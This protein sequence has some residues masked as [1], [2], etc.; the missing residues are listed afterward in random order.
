MS[1]NRDNSRQDGFTLIEVLV[2]L[3]VL[4]IGLLGLAAL[5]T[6]GVRFNHDAAV[7]TQAT[8]L[9]QDMLERL[10]IQRMRLEELERSG[11]PPALTYPADLVEFTTANFPAEPA[12]GYVCNNATSAAPASQLECWLAD[13]TNMLPEGA[14]TIEQQAA[15]LATLDIELM[16]L[17]R[18]PRSFGGVTRLPATQVECEAL[19]MRQWRNPNCMVMQTWT[20]TP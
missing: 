6:Q 16:W 20:V 17:D 5:Q 11:G 12:D 2:A 9:A 3:L 14:A 7:R 15:D 13:V 1:M 8:N 4:A 19:A 10:R 18:E